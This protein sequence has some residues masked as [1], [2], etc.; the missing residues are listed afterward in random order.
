[1]GRSAGDHTCAWAKLPPCAEQLCSV[2]PSPQSDP[3]HQV[4][5]KQVALDRPTGKGLSGF[6][7]KEENQK[8]IR[9]FSSSSIWT[10][11]I[12]KFPFGQKVIKDVR[13]D[14]VEVLCVIA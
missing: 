1:M 12:T 11:S 2:L 13:L 8:H 7:R 4:H 6:R 14:F 5:T 3:T 10:L 9:V